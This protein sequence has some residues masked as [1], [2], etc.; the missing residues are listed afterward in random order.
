MKNFGGVLSVFLLAL[1]AC[2]HRQ[3]LPQPELVQESTER[4]RKTGAWAFV[5]I[6]TQFF[7]QPERAYWHW[8]FNGCSVNP[9]KLRHEVPVREGFDTVRVVNR[10]TKRDTLILICDLRQDSTYEI[11]YN[12][13]CDDFYLF[14]HSRNGPNSGQQVHFEVKKSKGKKQWLGCIG[15]TAI[16]IGSGSSNLLT[17]DRTHSPMYSNR[18]KLY[19]TPYV[20]ADLDTTL[21]TLV[22]SR[23]GCELGGFSPQGDYRAAGINFTFLH[24]DRVRLVYDVKKGAYTLEKMKPEGK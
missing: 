7:P 14:S 2:Q 13:C 18:F 22:D 23:D 6:D 21:Y 10:R 4:S 24:A 17:H 20:P 15:N 8:W 11:Q 9:E 16:Q 19:V 5:E 3:A 1:V 12:T